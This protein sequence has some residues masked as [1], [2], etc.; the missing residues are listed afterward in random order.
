MC[1]GASEC[2]ISHSR[3]LSA[4]SKVILFGIRRVVMGENTTFVGNSFAQSFGLQRR[5]LLPPSVGGE[6]FLISRGVEIVNLDS[7]ECKDLMAEFIRVR[8]DI[9]NEDIGEE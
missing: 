4:T 2:A 6:D 5:D 3:L 8:P 7:T 1:S 9:W